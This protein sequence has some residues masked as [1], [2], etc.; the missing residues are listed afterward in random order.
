MAANL[1]DPAESDLRP[2]GLTI[3]DAAFP[4]ERR[5][6]VEA[7][8]DWG[9]AIALV[10]LVFLALDVWWLTRRPRPLAPTLA[11]CPRPPDRKGAPA[12]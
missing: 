10:A 7:F 11:S 6:K 8:H 3:D 1:T 2:R 4:V 9:W 5:E 12:S